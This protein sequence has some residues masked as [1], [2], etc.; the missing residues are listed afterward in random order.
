MTYS[1]ASQKVYGIR[2]SEQPNPLGQCLTVSSPSAEHIQTK[3]PK[4]F[5]CLDTIC[6]VRACLG[7]VSAR[8]CHMLPWTHV[9]PTGAEGRED[10]LS[11]RSRGN[12]TQQGFWQSVKASSASCYYFIFR[13]EQWIR[14]DWEEN[15]HKSRQPGEMSCSKWFLRLI[16]DDFSKLLG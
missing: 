13:L 1:V 12:G 9:S 5:R 8:I 16:A 14:N 2:Q 4:C 7:R 3:S 15:S 6:S 11:P 10:L